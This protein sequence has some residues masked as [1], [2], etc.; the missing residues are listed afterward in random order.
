M[1][2]NKLIA[3]AAVT[4]FLYFLGTLAYHLIYNPLR[5]FKGPWYTKFTKLPWTYHSLIGDVHAWVGQL[6]EE[7]GEIV[8][9]APDQLS[10]TSSQAWPDIYGNNLPKDLGKRL[11]EVNG[12]ANILIAEDPA[13]RR[14]RKLISPAFSDKALIAQ[15]P[16]LVSYIDKLISVLTERVLESPTGIVNIVQWYNYTAFDILGELALGQSFGGLDT[17]RDG[18]GLH[19]W[20]SSITGLL[21]NSLFHRVGNEHAWPLRKLIHKLAPKKGLKDRGTNFNYSVQAVQKRLAQSNTDRVDFFSYL[22]D[23]K[24]GYSNLRL[25]TGELISNASFFV[26]TGS[27]TISTFFS[28]TTYHLLTNP[29]HL[30]RLT[31]LLRTTFS[32]PESMNIHNLSKLTYLNAVIKEGLRVYPPAPAGFPR[33]TTA[34]GNMICGRYVPPNT[35]VIV[36]NWAASFSARNHTH[37]L[38]FAPERWEGAAEYAGDDRKACQPFSFGPRNCIAQSLANAEM[39]LVLARILWAFDLELQPESKNW[40]DQRAFALWEK[41]ALMV[42]ITPRKF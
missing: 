38:K 28:G 27:E 12:V 30:H 11:K 6:H 15:E 7:Y 33:V 19:P 32:T 35:V 22:S 20:I 1:S 39:R 34:Y 25:T 4:T 37:P 5:S 9:V 41:P 29:H 10:F 17:P 3:V 18:G 42:K 23:D 8:R 36:T 24:E 13:H 2:S 31:N 16:L 26:L 21:K 14:M 40:M